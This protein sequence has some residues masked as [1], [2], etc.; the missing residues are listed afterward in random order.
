M[1]ERE[2][3]AEEEEEEEEEERERPCC[4]D[5]LGGTVERRSSCA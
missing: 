5:G 2:K 4:W 3:K 1:K